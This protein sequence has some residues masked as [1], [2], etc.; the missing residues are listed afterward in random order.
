MAFWLG[1]D[2]LKLI[3]VEKVKPFKLLFHFLF[4]IKDNSLQM[5]EFGTL[6]LEIKLAL[7]FGEEQLR[8]HLAAHS[9]FLS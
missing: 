2:G 6:L 3:Q 1:E 9:A 8:D 7:K 4:S 5:I